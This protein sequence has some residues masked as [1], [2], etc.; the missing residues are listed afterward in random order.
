MRN[1]ALRALA[2][3][4]GVALF[5]ADAG[6]ENDRQIPNVPRNKDNDG[7]REFVYFDVLIKDLVDRHG[8]NTGRLIMSGFS[9]G[10]MMVWELACHHGD[11]FRAFIPIAS[12]FWVLV[13]A[14]YSARV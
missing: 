3:E 9:A 14:T 6:V 2:S 5:A 7:S 1:K 4:L 10:G 12:V 13:P 11:R 8:P